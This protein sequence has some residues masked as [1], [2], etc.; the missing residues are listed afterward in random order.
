[1][2]KRIKRTF[3]G[4]VRLILTP[5][6]STIKFVGGQP[7]MD[8]GVE[9]YII[10]LLFTAPGWCGNILLDDPNQKIGSD[11]EEIASRAITVKSLMDLEKAAELAL[12]RMVETGLAESV[13]AEASNPSG[14]ER[15][16]I[17]R[18]KRPN[19]NIEAFRLSKNQINWEFQRN[20]PAYKKV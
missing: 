20:D 11:F 9:T 3:Q 1:M 15:K 5:N 13:E 17:I 19:G 18:V 4:D 8:G 12:A 16:I 2:T 7:V 6:G 10:I 14:Q